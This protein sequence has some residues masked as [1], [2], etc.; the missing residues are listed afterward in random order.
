MNSTMGF[1]LC[2]SPLP[3]HKVAQCWV[4][5]QYTMGHVY[6]G[7]DHNPRSAATD[8]VRNFKMSCE[9]TLIMFRR[10][11]ARNQAASKV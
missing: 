4:N 3:E 1:V 5:G 7:G 2:V 6:W 8:A 11:R 10:A 9:Y